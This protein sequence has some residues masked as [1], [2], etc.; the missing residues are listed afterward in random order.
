MNDPMEGHYFNRCGNLSPEFKSSLKGEK[1]NYGICSLSK[2]SDNKLMWAHY[3]NGHAGI[4]IGVEINDRSVTLK[5]VNYDG[6]GAI[7]GNLNDAPAK[8][9]LEILSHKLEIWD[10]EK[11]VRAFVPDGRF[12]PVEIKEVIFVR[13]VSREDCTFYKDLFKRLLR[14]PNLRFTQEAEGFD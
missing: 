11:E 3:A 9:A 1:D 5:D 8:A 14:N 13:R 4:A 6:L 12:V 10:Y 7:T 2:I